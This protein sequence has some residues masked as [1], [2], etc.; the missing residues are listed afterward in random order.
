MRL[1]VGLRQR[2]VAQLQVVEPVVQDDLDRVRTDG[3]EVALQVVPASWDLDARA[4]RVE[5]GNLARSTGS[6]ASVIPSMYCERLAQ[7]VYT[8]GNLRYMHIWLRTQ[9]CIGIRSQLCFTNKRTQRS[10]CR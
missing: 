10:Y 9:A 3:R 5:E 8:C 7:D 1:V 6:A 4:V 2:H